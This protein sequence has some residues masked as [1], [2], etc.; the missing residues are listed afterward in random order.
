LDPFKD[1]IHSLLKEDPET[2]NV[3]ILQRIRQEGYHGGKTALQDWL[4]NVVLA[5][6]K[7][8]VRPSFRDEEDVKALTQSSVV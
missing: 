2:T 4:V 1:K 7:F 6:E 5:T 8:G 3:V